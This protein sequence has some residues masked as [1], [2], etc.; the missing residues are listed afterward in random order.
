MTL[1][2]KKGDKLNELS[3]SRREEEKDTS[4]SFSADM[5]DPKFVNR[6]RLDLQDMRGK[7]EESKGVYILRLTCAKSMSDLVKVLEKSNMLQ[8]KKACFNFQL[9]VRTSGLEDFTGYEDSSEEPS[10]TSTGDNDNEIIRLDWFS[11]NS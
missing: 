11:S 7:S 9:S 8:S 1:F 3:V 5:G 6:L 4:G 10:L 2:K